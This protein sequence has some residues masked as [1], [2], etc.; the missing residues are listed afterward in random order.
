MSSP[1][2]QVTEEPLVQAAARP[3]CVLRLTPEGLKHFA[4]NQILALHLKIMTLQALRLRER[5]RLCE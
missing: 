3:D 1:F 4:A 2:S 5:R